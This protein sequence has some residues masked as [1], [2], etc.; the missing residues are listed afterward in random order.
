MQEV[1]EDEKNVMIEA[2]D[3]QFEPMKKEHRHCQEQFY[4]YCRSRIIE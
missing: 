4:I 1:C 2:F 3:V